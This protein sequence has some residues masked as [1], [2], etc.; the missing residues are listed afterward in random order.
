MLLRYLVIAT[1]VICAL[2]ANFVFGMTHGVS[3]DYD[4]AYIAENCSRVQPDQ[5]RNISDHITYDR[6]LFGNVYIFDQVPG[7]ISRGDFMAAARG[8]LSEFLCFP[9]LGCLIPPTLHKHCE[10]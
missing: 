5:A 6:S 7:E 3:R 8:H 1:V 9:V 2:L 10:R 4:F